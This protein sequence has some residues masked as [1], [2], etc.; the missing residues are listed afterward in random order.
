MYSSGGGGEPGGCA[1]SCE[2][3]APLLVSAF[4]LLYSSACKGSSHFGTVAVCVK[5]LLA[6]STLTGFL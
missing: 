3:C 5:E 2:I 4:V 6:L 1:C